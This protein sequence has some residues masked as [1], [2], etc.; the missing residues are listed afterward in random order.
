MVGAADRETVEGDVG[1]EIQEPLPERVEAAPMLHMLWVDIGDD[2]DGRGQAVEAAVGLVGLD[3]HPFALPH[4]RVGAI[5]VDHAAIDHG[6]ID[7]ARIQQRR[8]HC[9]GRG[10]AMGARDGDVGFQPHQFGQHLGPAHDRQS[11][12]AGGVL[13]RV[14]ILDRGRDHD[15][16]GAFEVFR[17][18][19]DEDARAQGFQPLGDF[20]GFQ[21][22]AL[23]FVAMVQKHLGDARHADTADADEMDGPQLGRQFCRCVH[24]A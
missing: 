8:H 2:G 21:V 18:L 17:L 7:P 19:P 10:L 6:R 15:D 13:F 3:H 20:R 22:R 23:H 9:R 16:L 24:G 12:G 1:D 4:A 5:G 11:L 14:A